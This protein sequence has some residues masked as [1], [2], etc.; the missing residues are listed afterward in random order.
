VD[1][2]EHDLCAI[3]AKHTA[4]VLRFA[5]DPNA[6]EESLRS[7]RNAFDELVV[8]EHLTT[9]HR[10]D[11]PVGAVLAALRTLSEQSYEN[12]ALAFGCILDPRV[13]GGT[14]APQ[15]P[16]PLLGA[17]KY[18]AL[19]DGFR[20]AYRISS[21]GT[22]VDFVDL[23]K[24]IASPLT[25]KHFYPDWAADIARASR[26]GCCGIAL[27]RQGDILVFD[28]G[29][30]RFTYRYGRWQYWN[31][32]HLVGLLRDK[33]RVQKVQQKVRGQVVHSIYRAALDVSFR[34]SGGMFCILKNARELG[35][36]V[37]AGDAAGDRK[38][39]AVDRDFDTVV[40][41]RLFQSL[42]RPIA[43]ERASLDGA[44]VMANSGR[45]LAYGAVLQPRKSGA[46]LGTEGS[47]TKA[48]IGASFFGLA[49]KVSSDGDICIYSGGK[50]YLEV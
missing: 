25:E 8:A 3:I 35:S 31:H 18:K 6:N 48:A 20:T 4:R 43:V 27:S 17:K 42:P 36:I 9:H 16:H 1:I 5:D 38:R 30:L 24:V 34:R 10:L 50:K 14:S 15:F 44:M 29:T 37:R 41:Q 13:S 49:V 33:A 19:S 32:S 11:H 23:E 22:I 47:R 28:E 26:N 39:P 2:R 12:K 40:L 45:I 7:I 21:R 46:L